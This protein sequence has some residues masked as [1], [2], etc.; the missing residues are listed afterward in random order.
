[1]AS[2][3]IMCAQTKGKICS[4]C[5]LNTVHFK[6]WNWQS[7]MLIKAWA[8]AKAQSK[9]RVNEVHGEEE[10]YIVANESFDVTSTEVEEATQSGNITGTLLATDLP[11]FDAPAAALISGGPNA[12]GGSSSSSGQAGTPM[13][14]S[15]TGVMSFRMSFPTISSTQSPLQILPQFVEVLGKKLD[16]CTQELDWVKC[17]KCKHMNARF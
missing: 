2:L 6:P 8:W 1:M 17:L 3:K 9:I 4:A 5:S 13:L 12:A 16:K 10:I 14:G 7:N 11:D 15:T